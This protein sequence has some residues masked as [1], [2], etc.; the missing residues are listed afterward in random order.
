MKKYI[1]LSLLVI[2][3]VPNFAAADRLETIEIQGIIGDYAPEARVYEVNGKIYRFEEDISIKTQAGELLS[4]N[5]LQGGM[6]IKIMGEKEFGPDGKEKVRYFSI[7]VMK[8]KIKL[9]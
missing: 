5:D 7:I 1:L 6:S 2:L 8:K 9:K 4:F 3:L